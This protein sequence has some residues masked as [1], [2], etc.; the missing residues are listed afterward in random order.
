[1]VNG[2]EYRFDRSA[3]SSFVFDGGAGRDTIVLQAGPGGATAAL[4]PGTVDLNGLGYKIHAVNV[5]NATVRAG[6][7]QS[8]ATL[9]D[10][11]GDDTLVATPSYAE[12][13]GPGFVN[14]AEG[15][16]S[17]CAVAGRGFDVA[18][19]YD[20]PGNDTLSV[21]STETTLSGRG[22]SNRARFFDA[23]YA[24]GQSGGYDAAVLYGVSESTQLR[25]ADKKAECCS[26]VQRPTTRRPKPRRSCWPVSSMSAVSPQG[27]I[28]H[29]QLAGIGKT[30]FPCSPHC[31]V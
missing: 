10:S 8:R 9:Y 17:V 20:S 13:S 7:G 14:R 18:R 4:Q 3:V 11:P 22:F 2:V 5:E 29:A 16:S 1:M 15:F 28:S 24:D 26:A 19:L 12:L 6:L 31:I 23:V 25:A 21:A 30:V 27:T